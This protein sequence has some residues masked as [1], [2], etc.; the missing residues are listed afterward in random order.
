MGDVHKV[1]AG[2][3]QRLTPII[4]V[5]T[6]GVVQSAI[7]TAVHHG[8]EVVA[9]RTTSLKPAFDTLGRHDNAQRRGPAIQLVFVWHHFVPL[10]QAETLACVADK[11]NPFFENCVTYRVIEPYK[12]LKQDLVRSVQG[13][14]A[15]T[16]K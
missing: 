10:A 4:K 9:S 16:P 12:V 14:P 13:F 2:G 6:C 8:P 3:C 15:R 1:H 5:A 11:D 7:A